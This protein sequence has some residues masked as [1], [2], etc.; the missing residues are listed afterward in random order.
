MLFL[1]FF[2]LTLSLILRFSWI[3]KPVGT[4]I[5]NITT[6]VLAFLFLRMLLKINSLGGFIYSVPLAVISV[7]LWRYTLNY[8]PSTAV[9][10]KE[11]LSRFFKDLFASFSTSMEKIQSAS[12]SRKPLTVAAT[13]ELLKSHLTQSDDKK[14]SVEKTNVTAP[15]ANSGYGSSSTKRQ[16]SAGYSK[17]Y[18]K[19]S[20]WF[21]NSLLLIATGLLL[22]ASAAL[23]AYYYMDPPGFAE[24][25]QMMENKLR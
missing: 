16:K 25:L 11:I 6:F 9:D 14:S 17:S 21:F 3:K 7:Y 2:V 8:T 19:T 24:L 5:T 13:A 23:V 10:E 15:T 22:S 1:L 12:H 20:G 18:Q 4:T